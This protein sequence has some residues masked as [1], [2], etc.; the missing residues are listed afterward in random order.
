M[1][2]RTDRAVVIGAGVGGLVT[3]IE[4]ARRGLS[5]VVLE[6]ASKVGGKMR[7]VG[8][9][10][11]F[12]DAGP[13]VMTMR[14][15][16]EDIFSAAGGS[17]ADHLT[18]RPAEI[19]ARH[20]WGQGPTLD[21][22]ANLERTV[23]AIGS[24]A[25]R[26]EADGYRRFCAYAQRIYETVQKPFIE[27]ERPSL[28]S[29]VAAAGSI[30][31]SGLWAIDG[32]RT[33]WKALGE[34][35][36]DGR[37][38][39]LFGRYATYCGSS[40]F[41]A[42]ATLNVVAHVERE[43]VWLVEGGMYRVAEALA[44]LAEKL[45]VSIRCGE[46]VSEILVSG[47]R[48]AGVRLASGERI[49][50][51]IVA[52][53]GDPSALVQGLFGKPATRAV[54][55][56][57]PRSL[58]ALTW[59]FV[60]EPS[61][62]PLVRHNVFFCRDY[63]EEFHDLFDRSALP[64]EPT[65]YV[66]AQDRDDRD[67]SRGGPERFLCLV[68]APATGDTRALSNSEIRRCE[69]ATFSLLRRAGLVFPPFAEPPVVTTPSDFDRMFPATGGALYGQASHGW[70]SPFTRASS[71]TR[72]PGLYLAG[73]AAHPGAG[74]PMAALSGKLCAKAALEDLASTSQSLQTAMRGGTSMP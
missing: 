50:A 51:E 71:R 45:G 54:P 66:C 42:P 11:R 74:V 40:P 63:V 61:G 15:V 69:E 56:P 59:A 62:F 5:V 37:L 22:F 24:F 72:I 41:L 17:L 14:W 13:T 35:F 31:F 64:A 34:F 19:L 3:A 7:Q 9:A 58:S 12:I 2:S 60:A 39:Q 20:S 21:L 57:G 4:L 52:S 16:L 1:V 48:A 73:G 10:G 53:N 67:E 32:H 46:H 47:G 70:R 6:R 44:G 43:G 23:D 33:L 68:N 49:Q 36:Q 18:L 8:V 55:A 28:T 26:G 25:G 27:S 30:G 29:I 65:V 38:R